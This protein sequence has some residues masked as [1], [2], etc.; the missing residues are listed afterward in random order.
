MSKRNHF[1]ALKKHVIAF[2]NTRH[3]V[4]IYGAEQEMADDAE[5]AKAHQVAACRP[6]SR[7]AALSASASE[8]CVKIYAVG[9]SQSTGINHTLIDSNSP[10]IGYYTLDGVKIEQ[11]NAPGIYVVRRANGSNYK[12]VKK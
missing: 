7:A 9:V 3:C 11:P 8:N 6:L 5:T 4:Y 2:K 10:I 1:Y 12:L